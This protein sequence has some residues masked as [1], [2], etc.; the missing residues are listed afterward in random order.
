M[1]HE[2]DRLVAC[3]SALVFCAHAKCEGERAA[4]AFVGVVWAGGLLFGAGTTQK[5][6]NTHATH[7]PT[8]PKHSL[9]FD[10]LILHVPIDLSILASAS[11]LI[12]NAVSLIINEQRVIVIV[13]YKK[14]IIDRQFFH[15]HIKP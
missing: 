11:L 2:R 5:T 12:L 3:R 9:I 13:A 6:H 4:N 15:E 1:K 10:I 7:A 8:K 14:S